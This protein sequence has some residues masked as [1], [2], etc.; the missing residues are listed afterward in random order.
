MK[1]YLAL[2]LAA[3]ALNACASGNHPANN[4][5]ARASARHARQQWQTKLNSLPI[6][7]SEAEFTQWLQ[8]NNLLQHGEKPDLSNKR[9]INA[10]LPNGRFPVQPQVNQFNP[11]DSWFVLLDIQLDE[12]RRV[13]KK[14][15]RALGG[16]I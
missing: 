3:L 10:N 16:C 4:D 7:A 2:C 12:Q 1:K 6:G 11:C 14:E 5:P 13:A 15:A 9:Y 8:Q